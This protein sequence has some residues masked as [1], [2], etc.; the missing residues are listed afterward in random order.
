MLNRQKGFEYE[1]QVRE[2]LLSKPFTNA[3][4]WSDVP[5]TNLIDSGIID[6]HNTLRLIRKEYREELK[7]NP[8]IDTGIDI[9][10]LDIQTNKYILIQCKNNYNTGLRLGDLAGFYGWMTHLDKLEGI[11]YYTSKLSRNILTLPP[12]PRIKYL[13]HPYNDIEINDNVV[14][15]ENVLTESEN[16]SYSSSNSTKSSNTSNTSNTSTKIILRDN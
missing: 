9:V 2:Y 1:L 12:N 6:C 5:V 4:L 7:S 15:H 14:K 13:L 16:L 10:S 11:V 8:L 3:W